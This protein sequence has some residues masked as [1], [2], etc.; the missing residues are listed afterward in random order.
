[1][2]TKNKVFVLSLLMSGLLSLVHASRSA[3]P[4]GEEPRE[5][6]PPYEPE[7][8][9]SIYM[10]AQGWQKLCTEKSHVEFLSAASE[11]F[12]EASRKEFIA[13]LLAHDTETFKFTISRRI[14]I[15]QVANEQFLLRNERLNTAFVFGNGNRDVERSLHKKKPVVCCNLLI[16][17]YDF[18]TLSLPTNIVLQPCVLALSIERSLSSKREVITLRVF[19]PDR[20][21]G[22]LVYAPHAFVGAVGY[23]DAETHDW[24]LCCLA[25]NPDAAYL[26]QA[27]NYLE[28]QY[29]EWSI[30]FER[31]FEGQNEFFGRVI[32]IV[33]T[34]ALYERFD[35]EHERVCVGVRSGI[36]PDAQGSGRI[37]LSTYDQVEVT[38]LW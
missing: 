3:C 14:R 27:R 5:I 17:S 16:K 4:V 30:I 13:L 23:A 31:Y 33:P 2:V 19:E 26:F 35:L 25:N 21:M 24:L 8:R 9:T 22:P 38:D 20:H 6:L 37:V 10:T 1:M 28:L 7:L 36:V 12:D 29:D 34:A 15:G 11:H 18:K 32:E